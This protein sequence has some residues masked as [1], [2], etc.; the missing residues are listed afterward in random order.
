VL[1]LAFGRNLKQYVAIVADSH[2][3]RDMESK[4]PVKKF[5]AMMTLA[6]LELI[7]LLVPAESGRELSC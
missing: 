7:M 4:S 2:V 6:V 1:A 5:S 3:C